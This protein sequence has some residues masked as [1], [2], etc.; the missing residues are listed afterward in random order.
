IHG[1]HQAVEQAENYVARAIAAKGID[2]AVGFPDTFY[3]LPV[4]YSM[5]GRR[6]DKLADM[7]AILDECRL[8]LA[9]PPF[10]RVWLP[11]LGNALD[12]GMATL[13]AFEIVEACKYLIGPNP[14]NGIWLGAASDVIIRERGIEFV[15]GSAPGFAAIVGAAPTREDAV[16]IARELQEKNLY[17]FI[18]GNTNGVSFAEQLEE[19]GVQTGWETRLVPFGKDISAAIYALG[20]ANRAALSF[21]NIQ[22][23]DYERNLHYN[24]DRIFAFVM[25]LGEVTDEKYAAAAGAISYGF[26]TIADTDI[27]EILPTGICTYEH[28]VSSV[29]IDRIVE[30]CLEVRGCKVK[31]T[32]MPIPVAYGAAFEGERIRKEQTYLEF[33]G[34]RSQAFEYV[35][36]RELAEIEN[37]KIDVVGPDIDQVVPGSAL[38]LGIWVEVAGRKMQA[39]FEP[40]LERQIHHIVNGGE[41]IWHMGQRDINWIRISK[42]AQQKG[43]TIRHLGDM[44]HVRLVN[45]YPAIVDKVQITLFTEKDEIDR[46]VKDVRQVYRARNQRMES[47][48]DE[49]VDTFYSCLLCQSF[50]PSHVCVITPERLGLCGAYN[51]LDGK[52]AYEID[53]TGPNQPLQKGECI[54]PV[55]GQW[56]NINKYVYANSKQTIESFNAYSMLE[57]PMTSCGCFEAIVALLPECNGVMLVNREY[58]GQTPA[59]MKFSTLA[60]MAGGGQQTPGFLGIGKAYVTSRKFIAAE[61][62]HRRIVWMPS[63]LKE[64][65]R[66]D[67]E[68]IG[69][70]L[71]IE[72]FLDM[73]A[74]ETLTTDLGGLQEHLKKVNHPA[75]SMWEITSPSP[76]AAAADAARAGKNNG[77]K[78]PSA[79]SGVSP[80]EIVAATAGAVAKPVASAPESAAVAVAKPV[81]VVPAAPVAAQASSIA[82][83]THS[84]IPASADGVE[85]I[86][87]VLERLR[88]VPLRTQ[89]QPEMSA[90]QQMAAL[91]S[92][93]ALHLLHAGANML[94]MYSGLLGPAPTASPA[95][96]AAAPVAESQPAR[97][98]EAP[99]ETAKPAI[100]AQKLKPFSSARIVL[101]SSFK[102]PEE[103]AGQAIHLVTL[104]GSGTR[105]SAVTIGGAEV[106]PFRHFEGKTGSRAAI[107]MEVFDQEF[108]G[109]PQSLHEAYGALLNDPAAM[110]K[111][112]VEQLGADVIS[113]RL[114]GTHP[115]NG[116]RSP[117]ASADLIKDVL[118]AVGVPLIV[119]GT[120]HFEKNNA[121]MKHIAATF[122]GENLL[123]NW[124]ETDNYKTIAAAAMGY[125]HCI[126]AQAPIDVNMSKQLNILL[127]NMGVAAEKIVI[128]PY[129]GALGYGLEYTYS[130]M[131]RIRTSAFAGDAMLAMP[132]MT[133]PGYEVARTKESKAPVSAF[134]LWGPEGERGALI[135]I[136]TATSLLNAGADLLVMYHP[137]AARTMKRK[138]EEMTAC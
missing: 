17:T 133:A 132:M 128:D 34:S 67:F 69:K 45:D 84:A 14:V 109:Y 121:V 31:V 3:S 100:A 116:D 72:N 58:L 83:A 6:V 47:L 106:L 87:T 35:T 88:G 108:K 111:Y 42:A 115:E 63:S 138:I 73:I 4:I 22:P 86:L 1:A 89:L 129:T 51:W 131:E 134:P 70:S 77:A 5:L 13:F 29:P 120:N 56:E 122:A 27:P 21:G 82:A 52:A 119:T 93:T 114:I 18:A 90:E 92:S 7:G 81:E 104:G 99:V 8:L 2:S 36:T 65:L 43:F 28:V 96:S 66:E 39:D 26:P 40:I 75:L 113:V 10:D 68:E 136:A 107:A 71:G 38:P 20:F 76:E 53:P 25:A 11:Y 123:L 60:S 37:G 117:E 46:R 61:G 30:K 57:S 112:C 127:T 79:T 80:S 64:R 137:V 32:K 62:G 110:A 91:Q 55:R 103:G 59:G 74:D 44:I 48:T 126:V 118:K 33:G 98:D 78:T 15:D 124:A 19:A 85:E 9:A 125:N 105:T 95:S 24:K 135:E 12:A 94:L 16:R 101:P 41:G 50:A 23:G 102:V 97:K 130:V 54:D 49:T